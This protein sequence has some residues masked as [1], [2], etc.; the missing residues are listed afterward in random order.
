MNSVAANSSSLQE[1]YGMSGAFLES[2]NPLHTLATEEE[3]R[4]QRR[5]SII[6]NQIKDKQ[7]SST[8]SSLTTVAMPIR[9]ESKALMNNVNFLQLKE[10]QDDYALWTTNPGSEN[11]L[12]LLWN[13]QYMSQSTEIEHIVGWKPSTTYTRRTSCFKLAIQNGRYHPNQVCQQQG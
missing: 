9:F 2:R 13:N 11:Q 3:E 12:T 7:P 1:S 5:K 4:E 8:V 6:V 10:F